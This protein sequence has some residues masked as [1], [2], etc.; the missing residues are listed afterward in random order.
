MT[1]RAK[2]SAEINKEEM[3]GSGEKESQFDDGSKLHMFIQVRS[4][5]CKIV[6]V[7]ISFR[8]DEQTT[9]KQCV[10]LWFKAWKCMT[11]LTVDS[12][13]NG[14]AFIP[15]QGSFPRRTVDRWC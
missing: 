7:I 3:G 13:N 10:V 1:K 11:R 2:R 8:C 6:T 12:R 5:G 9:R 14:P 4:A 15:M